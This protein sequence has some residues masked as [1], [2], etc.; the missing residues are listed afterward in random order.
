MLVV[1]SPAKKMDMTQLS[2]PQGLPLTTPQFADDAQALA[3][4]AGALDVDG[5]M[6]LMGISENLATL[7]NDRFA[8]FGH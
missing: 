5:L 8:A 4:V 6:S 2:M 1:I 3:K 7:N